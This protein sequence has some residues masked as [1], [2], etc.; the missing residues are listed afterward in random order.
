MKA[1]ITT[2]VLGA[3]F[4][5]PVLMPGAHAQ[6]P[7]GTA[8]PAPAPAANTPAVAPSTSSAPAAAPARSTS[9]KTTHRTTK[10]HTKA[11]PS[12]SSKTIKPTQG[13]FRVTLPRVGL[14]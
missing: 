14:A 8:A 1:L 5:A 10:R 2:V 3:L 12:R 9:H 11:K 6:A 4:T 13:F 7:T